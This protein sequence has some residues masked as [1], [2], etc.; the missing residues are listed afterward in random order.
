MRQNC[1]G[2]PSRTAGPGRGL[3]GVCRRSANQRGRPLYSREFFKAEGCCNLPN[4]HLRELL[5]KPRG[6][7]AADPIR[8]NQRGDSL[9]LGPSR[10]LQQPVDTGPVRHLRL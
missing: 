2:I 4:Q 9:R 1:T 5:C 3:V 7:G 8:P 6:R 10:S